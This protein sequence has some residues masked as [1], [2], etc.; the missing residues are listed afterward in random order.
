[1]TTKSLR[2]TYWILNSMFCL[3]TATAGV[4]YLTSPTFARIFAA[5]GYPQYFRIELGSCK[6]IGVFVLLL[7]F[8][9]AV[10]EWAFAGFF[11]VL[12]SA[13]VTHLSVGDGL[14]TT[15]A[16]V[17]AAAILAV[18]YLSFRRLACP[19]RYGNPKPEPS[20]T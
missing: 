13:L 1:M 3:M 18:T 14:V 19:D 8:P 5:M 11:I 20:S 2:L 15:L 6:L 10:K 4:L 12:L 16:P 17:L 7:P 9:R